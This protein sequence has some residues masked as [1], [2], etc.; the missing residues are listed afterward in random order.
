MKELIVSSPRFRVRRIFIPDMHRSSAAVY[1]VEA[2]P[3]GASIPAFRLRTRFPADVM[4]VKREP[5]SKLGAS[6]LIDAQDAA[7]VVEA[8]DRS[9]GR[10]WPLW[11]MRAKREEQG[12]WRGLD[13]DDAEPLWPASDDATRADLMQCQWVAEWFSR[14]LGESRVLDVYSLL[15]QGLAGPA[16][17]RLISVSVDQNL[18]VPRRYAVALDRMARRFGVAESE[19]SSLWALVPESDG[20][21]SWSGLLPVPRVRARW[22]GA[23]SEQM[24]EIEFTPIRASVPEWTVLKRCPSGWA[25]GP[26]EAHKLIG[27]LLDRDFASSITSGIAD[28]QFAPVH[29]W[30]SLYPQDELS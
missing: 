1:E 23:G 14:L 8:A 15:G 11:A 26:N 6:N 25:P 13:G 17:G 18:S 22:V 24:V 21:S 29:R 30:Q 5:G 7:R 9:A 10:R 12:P 2:V 16:M 3:R 20:V 4:S 19:V 28:D 27:E